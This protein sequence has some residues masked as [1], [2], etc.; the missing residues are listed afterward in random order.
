M[1]PN[2]SGHVIDQGQARPAAEPRATYRLQLHKDF[3]F[4][5]AG[6]LAQYLA[7]LGISHVYTSPLL[8]AAPGSTHGYD[9][10]NPHAVNSEL[11][12]EDGFKELQEELERNRLG[13]VLDIVPNHMAISGRNN[14]WWWDVLENGPSSRYASYFDIDWQPPES[15][16]R[17]VVLMPILGEH[18]GKVLAQG[19]LK[20]ARDGGCFVLRYFDHVLPI[21]PRSLDVL[22]R[23]AAT[24]ARSDDLAFLADAFAALP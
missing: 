19:Q 13:L 20:L 1:L 6:H 18:Y 14:A 7:S 2:M 24:R 16:L 21:A 4:A 3:G 17:E 8:Q 12:G 11:G 22:L 9:V 5:Q 15:K 10:V 23:E